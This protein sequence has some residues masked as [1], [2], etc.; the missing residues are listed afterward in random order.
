[1]FFTVEGAKP[2]SYG[3]AGAQRKKLHELS[4]SLDESFAKLER[5]IEQ[6]AHTRLALCEYACVRMC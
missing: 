5:L 2:K 3:D 6:Y 4:N 1:M